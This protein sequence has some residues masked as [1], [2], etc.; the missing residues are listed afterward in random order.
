MPA[1]DTT[2]ESIVLYSGNSFHKRATSGVGYKL[3]GMKLTDAVE[4][5]LGVESICDLLKDECSPCEG[6]AF[7]H[8]TGGKSWKSVPGMTPASSPNVPDIQR[9]HSVAH[10][11]Y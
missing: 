2:R 1:G 6:V 8:Y 3:S 4:E 7:R 9:S 5:G 11:C 10:H